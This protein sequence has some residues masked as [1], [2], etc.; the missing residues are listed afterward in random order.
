MVDKTQSGRIIALLKAT[1][2]ALCQNRLDLN[3]F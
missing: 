2:R 1:E 3:D